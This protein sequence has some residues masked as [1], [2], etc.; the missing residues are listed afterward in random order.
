MPAKA[1]EQQTRFGLGL[2]LLEGAAF[3]R[4]SASSLT[5]NNLGTLTVSRRFDKKSSLIIQCKIFVRRHDLFAG[6]PFLQL[7]PTVDSCSGA[8]RY[9]TPIPPGGLFVLLCFFARW[10]LHGFEILSRRGGWWEKFKNGYRNPQPQISAP[11]LLDGVFCRWYNLANFV[12]DTSRN[13]R[14][15]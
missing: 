11:L 1:T 7:R 12:V 10:L 13:R 9:D 4:R 15:Q 5:F 14:A 6:L 3:N 2:V 8:R